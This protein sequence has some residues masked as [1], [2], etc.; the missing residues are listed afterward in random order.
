MDILNMSFEEITAAVLN[1]KIKVTE[2]KKAIMDADDS[3]WEIDKT[4][5]LQ[6][7]S[8]EL[9]DNGLRTLKEIEKEI[10]KKALNALNNCKE[11]Y[12]LFISDVEFFN[13]EEELNFMDFERQDDNSVY[14]MFKT[15]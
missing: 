11:Q 13:Y 8:K 10:E 5:Y 3:E 4:C 2:V 6:D 12:T 15:E 1:Q 14:L 9:K 7:I